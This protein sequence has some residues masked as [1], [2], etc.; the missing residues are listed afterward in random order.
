VS[1]TPPTEPATSRRAAVAKVMDDRPLL[2][3]FLGTVM[4]SLGPLLIAVSTTSGAVL[5]FWRLWL[6]AALLGAIALWRRTSVGHRTSRAGWRWAAGAGVVFGLHQ[7]MFMIAVKATS[8]VDVTLMQVLVPILVGVLAYVMFG[9]RPG[10]AFRLWSAVAVAGAVVVVLGG[11]TGPEGDPVGMALAVGNVV[12][13]AVYV[14]W[15]K[16]AM[17]HISV[18]PF[19]FGATAVAA[20]TVSVYVAVAGE[21]VASVGGRNLAIA[22]IIAVGPGALG[23]FL[24]THPLRRVAANIPPVMQLAMPFLS[25]GMAWLL[26]GQ[27]VTWLHVV[28]GLATVIGV[29]G[30]LLSPGGRRMSRTDD[31]S[32]EVTAVPDDA[33]GAGPAAATARSTD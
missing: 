14:V 18:L 11:T 1:V 12:F 20:M 21:A 30:A 8:V 27:P 17:S 2:L 15:S 4:F 16:R 24:S 25:G 6:G 10:A 9:E 33:P 29:V 28:G 3:L 22:A 5:S 26:L 23:H 31:A 7:V 32:S 19:L 13:F